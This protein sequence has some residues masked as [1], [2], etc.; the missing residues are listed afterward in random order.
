MRTPRLFVELSLS[1][2]EVI[3][4]PQEKAHH[5]AN[6]LRMQK[7]AAIKLFNN[8]D[9]E[10]DAILVSLTKKNAEVEVKEKKQIDNESPLKIILC[11]AISRGQHMDYSIQKAV[12]LGVHK[13]IPTLSEFCNVKIHDERLQNKLAHWQNIIINAAEQC[14]RNRLSQLELPVSFDECLENMLPKTNLILHPNSPQALSDINLE[15]TEMGLFIGPEGGF[16]ETEVNKAR[17]KATIPVRL[18]P[19]IL[20]S[21]TAVVSALSNVQQLWGDLN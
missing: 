12:E 10:F 4:L 11:L 1:P 2:G 20:R 9:Y 3:S 19:R 14:G 7:G 17:E 16:S 6:V 21:E 8:T 5:I 13:I 15:E 18:G